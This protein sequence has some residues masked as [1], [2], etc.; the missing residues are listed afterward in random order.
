MDKLTSVIFDAIQDELDVFVWDLEYNGVGRLEAY[1][2]TYNKAHDL[3]MEF[4]QTPAGLALNITDTARIDLAGMARSLLDS[5]GLKYERDEFWD[6]RSDL[7]DLQLSYVAR[8]L[9]LGF[10]SEPDLCREVCKRAGRL[11]EF[12]AVEC[13]GE[14]AIH[15][16]TLEC[17]DYIGIT[18]F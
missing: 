11:E 9:L 6:N 7:T 4:L 12:L 1:R 16:I 18:L 10:A 5:Y 15:D 8:Q 2:R 17:A 3:M 14:D 13:L